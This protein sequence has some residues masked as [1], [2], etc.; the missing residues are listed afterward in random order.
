MSNILFSWINRCDSG[1]LSGGSWV[2]TL[3]LNNLKNRQVQ[4]VARSTDDATSS[5]QFVIDLLSARAIGVLA[6]AAHNIS[7]T[8]LV[9]VMGH[10]SNSWA[11]P[12]YT[13]GWLPA[14]PENIALRSLLEWEDNEFW[15]A[16]YSQELLTGYRA[17]FLHVLPVANVL[18]YWRVEIDDTANPDAYVQ[19]GRLF[20]GPAWQPD[21]NYVY[22]AELVYEDMTPV[23]T[24]LSGAEYFDPR[25]RARVF[26]CTLG[27]L[28]QAEAYSAVMEMQRTAGISGE[29][30]QVPDPEDA[31]YAPMRAF[32]GRMRRLSPVAHKEISQLTATVE[33]KESI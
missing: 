32:V 3:P 8:G 7:A 4:R 27:G 29:V 14:W 30:L 16:N 23:E 19:I 11:S 21:V 6:L 2:S 26:K 1:T 22:G 15:L 24:S 17:P 20:L 28:D 5:T 33:I 12:T 10:T 13:S 25:P 31:T 18:R 9:R